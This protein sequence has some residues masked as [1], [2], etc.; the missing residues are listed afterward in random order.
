MRLA[1]GKK[2][3]LFKGFMTMTMTNTSIETVSVAILD[4][5]REDKITY[6]EMKGDDELTKIIGDLLESLCQNST[7]YAGPAEDCT[8]IYE[9]WG[10]N[11][12]GN[13]WR[14]HLIVPTTV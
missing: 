1:S 7:S 9:F 4:S 6:I 12:S 10:T 2:P 13:E 5:V 14:V 3:G 11:G 8:H